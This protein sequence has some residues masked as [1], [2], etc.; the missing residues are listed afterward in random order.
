M[1]TKVSEGWTAEAVTAHEERRAA[2]LAILNDPV[3][4]FDEVFGRLA[5]NPF[6]TVL[7]AD[8]VHAAAHAAYP[9]DDGAAEFAFSNSSIRLGAA[10]AVAVEALRQGLLRSL[11]VKA[12]EI[13]DL[14]RVAM[15][16]AA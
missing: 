7:G 5:E 6:D 3:R 4:F 15:R 10:W 13:D 14:T 1:S 16:D 11:A 8:D 12:A 9:D 2:Q